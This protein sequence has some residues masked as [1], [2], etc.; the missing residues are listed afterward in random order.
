MSSDETPKIEPILTDA[1]SI[2]PETKPEAAKSEAAEAPKVEAAPEVKVEPKSE[3][4]KIEPRIE[5]KAEAPTL[6]PAPQIEPP[7]A[8][9]LRRR[10][11][12]T[13]KTAAQ[14]RVRAICPARR[15]R[16]DCGKHWRDRRLARRREI[17]PDDGAEGGADRGRKGS[18]RRNPRTEGLC[19]AAPRSHEIAQRQPRLAEDHRDHHHG[20]GE[21]AERQDRRNTRAHREGAGRAEEADGVASRAGDDRLDLQPGAEAS[22]R[23]HQPCPWCSA[24]RPPR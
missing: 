1:P 23:Q 9:I 17:R 21:P 20:H 14:P 22:S 4:A 6:P 5:A 3:P 7:K 2:A 8:I 12:W 18:V 13:E 24:T 11:P 10:Q 15:L 16:C 19:C